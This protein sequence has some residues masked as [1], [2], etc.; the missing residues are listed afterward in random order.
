MKNKKILL[1]ILLAIT[2]SGCNKNDIKYEDEYITTVTNNDLLSNNL[3]QSPKKQIENENIDEQNIINE[4]VFNYEKSV[5]EN[6]INNS[7]SNDNN[8]NSDIK[9]NSNLSLLKSVNFQEINEIVYATC[10]VN[11]R[12]LPSKDSNKYGLLRFGEQITRTGV[13]DNGWSRVIYNDNILYINSKFL[14]TD[15]PILKTSSYIGNFIQK[16]GNVDNVY[17]EMVSNQISKIPEKIISL[18]TNNDSTIYVTDENLAL[19]HCNGIYSSLQGVTI[20]DTNT[21]L[22]EDRKAACV[23]AT[24]HECGHLFDKLLGF[25]SIYDNNFISLYEIEK[26]SLLS[27]SSSYS[28]PNTT[29]YFA[30]LF[31][32]YIKNRDKLKEKC[33]NSFSFI[34]NKINSL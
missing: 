10:D 29:E 30:E 16:S 26:D 21:I 11:I 8:S 6:N 7:E 14:S 5:S 33:P 23:G 24:V 28:T 32:C 19:T 22:I 12:E 3:N 31:D 4:E 13:G 15:K 2:F 9:N 20:Y 1:L 18:L 34:E 17:L 25:P 27:I